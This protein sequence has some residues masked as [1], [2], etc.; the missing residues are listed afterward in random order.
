MRER[1]VRIGAIFAVLALAFFGLAAFGVLPAPGVGEKEFLIKSFS[2]QGLVEGRAEV[3][4]QFNREAAPADKIGVEL[5]P[6][7]MPIT[8]SP[9]LGGSGRWMDAATFVFYPKAGLLT[10]ATSYTA[11][12]N[13]GLRDREG[14][15]LS[16]PQTFVFHSAP[17]RFLGAKQ[18]N[19][20]I[21]KNQTT[22]ELNFSLP[23][24]PARLRGYAEVK[25]A[26]RR[27]LEF[28]IIQGPA[29][30]RIRMTVNA[31]A[32]VKDMRL[33]L[34]AG[35]PSEAGPLGLEKSL[36]VPL[37]RSAKMEVRG[38]RA[39]SNMNNG[40]VVFE[41]AAPVDF[42]KAEAFIEVSPKTPYTLEPSDGGFSLVGK[43]APQDRIRVTLKKGFPSLGG[44]P[45]DSEWSQAFIFPEKKPEIRFAAPG[46]ILSPA[47]SLRIPIET[48]NLDK[49]QIL[50]WK[51]Y[52]NN[53]PIGMRSAWADYPIDLSTMLANKD[54]KVKGQLN[55]TVRSALDLKPLIKDEKGVFL[56]IAQNGDGEWAESRQ[57]V[58]VTDLGVTV[59]KGPDS[60]LF[61][62]NSVKTG[63]AVSDAKVT[64]WSWANQ[65]VAEGATDKD[66][67]A[68]VSFS[69]SG[70]GQPV[71]ATVKKDGD[72]AF[73][74]L[75]NGLYQGR[76]EFG[77]EGEGWV[78]RG[79]SA[80]CYLPR[81]IFRPGENVH[82]RTVVRD[83]KHSAPQPFPVTLKVYTPMGRIW[84]TQTSKLS[85]EGA[86]SA[87]FNVPASAP[88]GS[89]SIH[90]SAPGSDGIIG[91]REFFVEEFAAPRLF[92]EAAVKPEKLI[93][94]MPAVLS[95]SS[96]YAFGSPASGL[97]WEAELSTSAREFK[98]KDWKGF[99]FSDAEKKFQPEM[100]YLADGKLDK[101][102][103]TTVNIPGKNHSAPSI[104]DIAV[105]AGVM[106]ESGRWAYKTA[107]V[108]WYPSETLVGIEIPKGDITPNKPLSF[109]VAAVTPEGD[110]AKTE[111]L[112][113]SFFRVVRQPVTYEAGGAAKSRFQEEYIPRGDGTVKLAAGKGAIAVNPTEGGTYLLR[114]EEPK[115]GA[116]ASVYVHVYGGVQDETSTLPDRVEIT[117][118]K[119]IYKA[120]E[121]AKVKISAPFAG[122]LLL[123]VETYKVVRR[124][125]VDM[126]GKEIE[127]AVKVTD[128]MAPNG[129]ITAQ[130]VR[131]A[132]ESGE[133]SRAYGTAP[134]MLD[135]SDKKL[136]VEI[137][138]IGRLEPGKNE[139]SLTVRDSKGHGAEV[140][141][142][143]MLVDETV[144]GLTGYETPDPW[145]F[146]TAKRML[147][148]ETYDLY[149][150]L[151]TPEKTAT[152]LLIAGGG[153]GADM[154]KLSSNLNPVQARRFKMLSLI[155][156]VR[157]DAKG[158]CNFSFV[159][160]EFAGKARLMAVA[161]TA[162]AAG[163][164]DTGVDINREVVLEPS[165]PRV[166]A[167]GDRFS[168]PC[169][170]F[171][172]GK[173]AR[174]VTLKIE[175]SGPIRLVGG[176]ERKARVT[177]GSSAEFN[178]DFEGA[179]VGAAKVLFTAQWQGGSQKSAIELAVRPASPKVTESWSG[180]I[181]PGKSTV[182]ALPEK[183]LAG[184]MNGKVMLSATPSVAL[185]DIT[186]FLASYP[187]GC[188]EQ[189]VSSAWPL[190]AQAGDKSARTLLASKI[191]KITG[192]QNYDGGFVTWQGLSWS[193]PWNSIYGTHFFVEAERA[194]VRIPADSYRAAID[195]VRRLL[196]MTP[197]D[198]D[199]E[200]Q[201]RET[202]SRR[203]YACYVLALSGDAPVGWMES[204]R[205]KSDS[206]A[207]S[208]RLFLAA[209]YAASGQKKEAEKML[210]KKLEVIKRI[211]G[212]ND[213]YDS[214]LRNNALYLLVRDHV[215]PAGADAASAAQT[216]LANVKNAGYYSTQEAA[217]SFIALA[218]YFHAQPV[219]GTPSGRLSYGDKV[220]GQVSDKTRAVSSEV[221]EAVRI[222]AENTG[223]ARL[224]AAWTVS[225][226]PVGRV[227]N[228]DDGIE[229]RQTVMGRDGRPIGAKIERG[230]A[231]TATVTI[232]PKAGKLRDVAVIIPLA[233]G[234]EIENARYAASGVELPAGVRSEARDDRLLLYIDSLEKPL[235]WKY[236]LRPVTK[237]KFNVPQISAE[238]MYDPAVVSVSGGGALEIK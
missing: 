237:G 199:D 64:L 214:D 91:Y 160:P 168:A 216:L 116:R 57:I 22:F 74:R 98:H 51:L 187:H 38:A 189:T 123:D 107:T 7:E 163:C 195:Y 130:V 6:S 159:I 206:L 25:D 43:F 92:V 149:N 133:A 79:Y 93:G 10:Q 235:V 211:P 48:V 8:F 143:V 162:K 27:P 136:T 16:G 29:S 167:P 33:A 99:V 72:V 124:E 147:G 218:K 1:N 119:N 233:A 146:F 105:T 85:K 101:D 227:K 229:I 231:L 154:M 23:V 220:L 114:A 118:D 141:V 45:L 185:A 192:M 117:T 30:R 2:P 181:E 171:N 213:N 66:G 60:A 191:Q 238:C 88:T 52:E 182:L 215:D 56:V 224:F 40:S 208:G 3:R 73:V 127:R 35:L 49:I 21:E 173:E 110:A 135:N 126:K 125:V 165:M 144:L 78:Y 68:S 223:A 89:W 44:K 65:A 156:S 77:A 186:G 174:D 161:V 28:N 94:D 122:R 140:D 58:N 103:M 67:A 176:A 150:A 41:M 179:G 188:M 148:V 155:K 55:K 106:E 75:D 80:Y 39:T 50:V 90:V 212:G 97:G 108:P 207:P 196:P 31:A 205:D 46:R 221:K 153:A 142:T 113:Y 53:I 120:G 177:P 128:E 42:A 170:I 157:S 71:I 17:L 96:K 204:L 232:K 36:T 172:R 112:K 178:L 32:N 19:F 26:G 222:K 82:V 138:N 47:G 164:C 102:G 69:D 9:A 18:I 202:L 234:L 200:E 201:W 76:D 139:F 63:K 194:G 54:Y 13:N 166:L 151:I 152:P 12:A 190:L 104:L 210:G 81:E 100:E 11:T 59:K 83:V 20:D 115:S 183:W 109:N 137:K 111:T 230:A 84:T 198:P 95:V 180:I 24:S 86:C 4:V 134:L 121:T 158:A 197:A 70:D 129:W 169:Q 14:R 62:I 15:L 236:T 5:A 228:R 217:F 87:F 226:V 203:A 219:Q 34:A 225:G 145:K 132:T 131:S 209:A 175:C 37:V 61:W 193:Q 184:T